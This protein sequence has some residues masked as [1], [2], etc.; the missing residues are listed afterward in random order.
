MSIASSSK[1]VVNPERLMQSS[2]TTRATV[3]E[4]AVVTLSDMVEGLRRPIETVSL[5]ILY[6]AVAVVVLDAVL[7]MAD[8]IGRAVFGRPILG[9]VELV[10]NT[11]VLIIFCQAPT[12]IM[13]GRMLRVS[14]VLVRLPDSGQR[15]VEAI[16]CILGILLFAALVLD[17]WEPMLNAWRTHEMDGT[18]NL[19]MPLA[20]VRSALIV[21]WS[22]TVVILLYALTRT[23]LGLQTSV[24]DLGISH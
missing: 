16:T 14:A 20:P 8:V 4:P 5:V 21:L 12:T 10:R 11:V 19:K 18:I 22:Y 9:T 13:E 6:L 2:T 15:L 3:A 17:M 23:V 24:P 7:I 1:T